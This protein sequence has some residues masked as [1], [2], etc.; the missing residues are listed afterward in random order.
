MK[1]FNLCA[2][3]VVSAYTTV[4][5]NTLEEA[6]EIAKNRPNMQILHTGGDNADE[7]WMIDELD[8]TPSNIIED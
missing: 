7:N 6:I 3:I 8:G 5:A 1:T 2:R 4:E